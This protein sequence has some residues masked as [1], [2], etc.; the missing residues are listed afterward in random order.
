[1]VGARAVVRLGMTF[2]EALDSGLVAGA[3]L[4]SKEAS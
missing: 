3:A 4:C 2:V 1:V